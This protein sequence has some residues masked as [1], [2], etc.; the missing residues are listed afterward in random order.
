MI[1][2]ERGFPTSQNP[3]FL[4]MNLISPLYESLQEHLRTPTPTVILRNL[5]PSVTPSVPEWNYPAPHESDVFAQGRL[6]IAKGTQSFCAM[7]R[8]HRGNPRREELRRLAAI[9]PAEDGFRWQ[10]RVC[11]DKSKDGRTNSFLL[12]KAN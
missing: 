2:A 6:S 1:A 11:Y 9:L 7:E 10:G 5:P 8:V 4:L 12:T 3:C